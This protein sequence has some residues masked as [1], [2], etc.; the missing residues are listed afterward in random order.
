M[1]KLT[2]TI[3]IMFLIAN[4]ATLSVYAGIWSDSFDRAELGSPWRGDTENFS[5]LDGAVRGIN[6]H[7][8]LLLPLKW[9]EVG[10][11]WDD[12]VVRCRINVVT[13]NLLECTKGALLLR[14]SGKE[15]YVF[16]LHVATKTVE[17][18]SLSDGKMLL[19]KEEPLELET[20]YQVRAELQGE[21]MSFFVDDKL[22]G[23]LTDRRSASGSVGLAV[24][25]TLK[26]LFDDFSVTGPGVDPGTAGIKREEKLP[27]V[28]ASI[29]TG[30][31]SDL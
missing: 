4:P 17:V 20:W 28:W 24:Q 1:R 27:S 11:G 12:Y 5:I 21:N 23:K 16:A 10:R 25:D 14:H 26:V 3:I 8:I 31:V 22:I 6:A 29:K 15:G 7:P 13:P 19:S 18:Y 2:F 9:V 30:R